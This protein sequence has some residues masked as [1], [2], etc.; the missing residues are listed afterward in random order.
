MTNTYAPLLFKLA[1]VLTGLSFVEMVSAQNPPAL[2]VGG[3][4]F[5]PDGSQILD[6]SVDFK[7]QVL[8]ASGVCV[9]YSESHL[10]EDLSLSK[11]RFYLGLGQ[12]SGKV[13]NLDASGQLNA[14]IFLNAGT[15][16]V[17]NCAQPTVAL[18]AG[19]AR[20][21][22]ISYDLGSG[23]T[24]LTPDV[25]LVSSAYAMI[26]DSL[27]GKTADQFIQVAS[28]GSSAL[29][30]ANTQFAFSSVNWPKLQALLNGTSTQYL[31]TSPS[32][33]VDLNGQ[34]LVNVADP[35][36][37]Q[38]AATKNYADTFVAG[39]SVDVTAVGPM[40]GNG[41]VLLWDATA[42]KW[43]ASVINTSATGSAGGDLQGSYPNPTIKD[44]AVTARKIASSGGG[45]NRLLITDAST[46]TTVGYGSCALNEV[47]AWTAG[48]WAC[49][50]V[51]TLAPVTKVAGR[52]GNVT[53][54][55][56]DIGSLGTAAL[57]DYGTSANQLTRLDA[58]ARLPAVDGS[59][60]TN[61]NA[62]QLQG[63]VVAATAPTS[64]Q[65]LGFNVTSSQWEPTSLPAT[66]TGT[67]ASVA[68]G[69]G[70]LGGPIT[71]TGTL[72]V[73]VGSTANKIVREN[74]NAQI[75]QLLGTASLPSYSFTGDTNTGLYSPGA[76]QISLVTNGLAGVTV[77]ASGFVGLGTTL[78][79]RRTELFDATQYVARVN[80]TNTSATTLEI[81]NQA[82]GAAWQNSVSGTLAPFTG[83]PAGSYFI[84]RQTLTVPAFTIDPT[85]LVGVGSTAPKAALDVNGTGTIASALIVP[86]D[87]TAMRPTV[88]V[89]GM[90]RY[91]SATSK[92]EA[93]ENNAWANLIGG[94]QPSF[95]LL[96]NPIGSA[97]APAYSFSG[98][99]NTGLFSPGANQ[100]AI[101]ANGTAALSVVSSGFIGI[102]TV[103]P[104]QSLDVT[105]NVQ[106]SSRYLIGGMNAVA[107]PVSDSV[108]VGNTAAA[109]NT[110]SPQYNTAV[111][112]QALNANA[113]GRFNTALGYAT[114]TNDTAW[115][116][117]AVGGYS[118]TNNTSGGNNAGLG[119]G[120]GQ[121]NTT[122]IN[123]TY[124]GALAGLG[125]ST[126]SYNTAVGQGALYVS[127]G[128][129]NTAL[130]EE[131]G[132]AATTGTG[133]IL[134]GYNSANNLTTGSSNIVIG[135]ATVATPTGSNQLNIGNT[136]FGNTNKGLV[137]VGTATPM[138]GLDVA[139]TGTIASAL[140]VPRDTTAMRPTVAV[141][142]MIRYNSAT[143]KF[144]AFENN[145]WANMI[146][147]TGS[148]SF[149]LLANPVGTAA[150]P[151]YSFNGSATTGMY[152]PAANQL[153]LSTNG[154]AALNV[155]ASGYVGIGTAA[156]ASLLH[157]S[158][159]TSGYP[160]LVDSTAPY[161][162]KTAGVGFTLAGAA[163]GGINAT[164][165]S[166]NHIE[167]GSPGWV[168]VTPRLNVYSG[169]Y[170]C[171]PFGLF[172]VL[173]PACAFPYF[174]V[175]TTGNVGVGL[176]V[177][178]AGLDVATTGTIASALIVPRDTTAMRPTVAVNGMI[179]LQHRDVEV[180]GVREQRVDEFNRCGLG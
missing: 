106:A 149:P 121:G 157:V 118:L 10:G 80:S 61:V 151:A 177:P 137:G 27:Q 39:K 162:N 124:L 50:A 152:S 88:A 26:A 146:A 85:G 128:G 46:G 117:T 49:T 14:Q 60:L 104:A 103:T 57:L 11:G 4:L 109:L 86:R 41:S 87:T 77:N 136:L 90:I 32:M 156:P 98:N 69:T 72:S 155:L 20:Q 19:D 100:V 166:S 67:V 82:S 43:V 165:Y 102:G 12:G 154:T 150:A 94:A 36:A 97:A 131:A 29:T 144:E 84:H 173:A 101:S 8:D 122:G 42:N 141:N 180:R 176:A 135:A 96:A 3:Q 133:N 52:T 110:S 34:R 167:I 132:V 30:Q 75:E 126:G 114:L 92:F 170:G 130:G 1:L 112:T 168:N 28:N 140:I 105:G 129:Y 53:L 62:T 2:S 33:P 13:N 70:L 174:V 45:V 116:N 54:T 22:R 164:D 160:I 81:I 48:G 16:P 59:Q 120:A 55:A 123:N 115:S 134:I 139:S 119:Y 93:F 107:I 18:N 35:T 89:N 79:N 71:S 143:S 6:N 111:G 113:S 147:A 153:A 37:A 148:T 64:A 9:L 95:P 56:A 51:A 17:A 74:A 63:R 169:A 138:A 5:A 40:T 66:S 7:V 127:T 83:L 24:A 76:D 31:G 58:S 163:A 91:N 172:S 108:V 23:L 25:P 73:D 158:M 38:N 65:V 68:S 99:A 159:G 142:G 78:P 21:I 175:T 145:A 125:N 47:Y 15:T 179:R 44:D 171:N 178:Q 161:P